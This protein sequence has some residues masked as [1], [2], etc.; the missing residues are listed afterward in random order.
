MLPLAL[1][2]ILAALVLYSQTMAFHW[3]EGFHLLAAQLIAAGKRPYIDFL[4]AQTPL[5][6]FWNAG[7]FRAFG[8]SWR[9]AHALAALE[10][11]LAVV[12][13]SGYAL[14]RF[15]VPEWRGPAAISAAALF[16]C[17]TVIFDFGT[18]GQAYGFCLL[19]LAAAFRLSASAR[20]DAGWRHAALAGLCAGAA[21]NASLLAAPAGP[22]LLL[23]L[24]LHNAAGSRRAKAAVFAIGGALTSAPV[25]YLLARAPQQ[26]W[27]NLVEYHALYR[28]V[29]W[30]GATANDIAVLS[31][32]LQDTQ[33]F[34]LVGLAV[35][36]WIF[37]RK[38]RW[39][40]DRR[41]ELRLC[42]WLVLAMGAQSA[43]AHPT[44]EQYF[45]FVVP[46][47]AL[48]ACAGAYALAL[49]VSA[50]PG[51]AAFVLG[52]FMAVTLMRAIYEERDSESWG[53]LTPAARKVD[54]VTPHGS[55]ILAQEQIYL[56]THRDP[57]AGTESSFASKLD[58]G[59]QRNALLHILP[60]AEQDRQIKAGR[61]RAAVVCDYD[62]RSSEIAKLGVFREKS[63][64]GNCTV[65]WNP[66]PG[67]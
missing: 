25:L 61:F 44:F 9:L 41:A 30:S 12:L 15:P 56:L 22:V 55:A 46:F 19:L 28:R 66:S 54:A 33:Y 1:A 48:L 34:V 40:E 13:I 14:K 26:A 21:A 60:T 53:G 29:N 63:E 51:S 4:F 36:G 52:I 57:P 20:E 45:I 17:L 11:W 23:W 35:G 37:I 7:W 8:Q 50:R 5:N 32:W 65:F 3:D 39:D 49:R 24:W 2:L 62:S 31:A 6:A 64:L 58:L 16:G 38:S 27:F 43:V 59:A 67:Q 42:L 18:V 47:L 10:T